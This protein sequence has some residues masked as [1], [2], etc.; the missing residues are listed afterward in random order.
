MTT[1]KKLNRIDLVNFIK[2][3]QGLKESSS[4]GSTYFIGNDK[5]APNYQLEFIPQSKKY[6]FTI[7]L[8][9]LKS[10]ADNIHNEVLIYLQKLDLKRN[11]IL[12]TETIT[13]FV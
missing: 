8:R 11:I 3:I 4:R 5:N 9:G 13:S 2:S 1:T 6:F 12:N 7:Y 10:E